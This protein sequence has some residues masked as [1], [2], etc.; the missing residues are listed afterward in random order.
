MS[1]DLVLKRSNQNW[2]RGLPA[3]GSGA[4][5]AGKVAMGGMALGTLLGVAF[6]TS[7]WWSSFMAPK[8]ARTGSHADYTGVRL[9]GRRRRG[10]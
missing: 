2:A 6:V 3:S 9:P 7:P 8:P 4:S 5:T 1:K 10:T